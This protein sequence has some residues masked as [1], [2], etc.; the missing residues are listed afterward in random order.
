MYDA[1]PSTKNAF[2]IFGSNNYLDIGLSKLATT[3]KGFEAE[4]LIG[5]P[6]KGKEYSKSCVG[7]HGRSF[8]GLISERS[9]SLPQFSNWY[10][11]GQLQKYKRDILGYN[12]EDSDGYA[13]SSL[14]KA[15]SNQQIADMVAYIKTFKVET[16]LINTLNGDPKN[17]KIEYQLNCMACHQKNGK[18]NEQL[19]APSLVGLSD[20]YIVNQL[21]K[22]RDEVRGSGNGDKHGKVMQSFAKNLKNEQVMKD[23]AAYLIS[24][25]Y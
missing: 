13:M 17:G 24:L 10:M 20:V 6:I 1:S 7:C 14:M 15:Y 2:A 5:D 16:E 25:K 9:P 23:I 12:V 21:I 4:L 8:S 19:Y 3:I 18:G 11:Q 22:Y